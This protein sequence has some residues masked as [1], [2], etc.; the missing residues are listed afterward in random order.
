M[1]FLI[2][3]VALVLNYSTFAEISV[4]IDLMNNDSGKITQ[5]QKKI[6]TSLDEI[7]TFEIPNSNKAL[8]VKVSEKLPEDLMDDTLSVNE[9]LIDVKII[10]LSTKDRKVI[11][12]PSISTILG[13]ETIMEQFKDDKSQEKVFSLKVTSDAI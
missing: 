9:V 11:A 8:E 5:F 7:N 1:K 13:S 10:D 3:L 2:T 4:D 12:S 6:T